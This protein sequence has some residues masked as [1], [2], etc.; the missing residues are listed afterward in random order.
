MNKSNIVYVQHILERVERIESFTYGKVEDDFLNSILLQ[1]AV[2]RNFEVIG[3]ATKNI[4][5]EFKNTH[6]H[7]EWK[8]IAR[9]RDK[10]IHHY[11]VVD[12]EFIWTTIQLMIPPLKAD[13]LGLLDDLK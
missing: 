9:M 1:D 11:T 4:S 7:I 2:I 10:L 5:A 8:K 13:L 12:I 6:S 3:E